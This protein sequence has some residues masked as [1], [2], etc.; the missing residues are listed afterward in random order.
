M[1]GMRVLTAACTLLLA[2]VFAPMQAAAASPLRLL[3]IDPPATEGSAASYPGAV[4]VR[5]FAE[6]YVVAVRGDWGSATVLFVAEA[7][8][9]SM[10]ASDPRGKV[11]VHEGE[12]VV[13]LPA[14]G[15]ALRLTIPTPAAAAPAALGA[16][17]V[18]QLHAR[19]GT[20]DLLD[21]EGDHVVTYRPALAGLSTEDLLATEDL[22]SAV[23]A[24]RAAPGA[25]GLE[26]LTASSFRQDP[27]GGGTGG[28]SS[29]CSVTC[30]PTN[31]SCSATGGGGLSPCCTCSCDQGSASCSCR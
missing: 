10:A 9:P 14:S 3:G 27:N 21:V 17:Q 8:V 11:L 13:V 6:G 22:A 12:V 15:E 4:A 20:R 31:N 29:S 25:R 26:V 18:D 2:S 19:Q 23:A 24:L 5:S 28:C 30:P 1:R 7:A 16:A